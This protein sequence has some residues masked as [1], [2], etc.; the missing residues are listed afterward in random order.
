MT[1]RS[2]TEAIVTRLS[3][4]GARNPLNASDLQTTPPGPYTMVYSDAGQGRPLR[5]AS[6]TDRITVRWQ[7]MSV[8][9]SRQGVQDMVQDVRNAITDFS[10]GGTR[11][12]GRLSEEFS[13]PLMD[14]KTAP[15]DSRYSLTLNYVMTTHRGEV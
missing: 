5:I 2:L 15:L 14:I 3:D 1:L 10:P 8:S 11:E 12:S 9:N 7:I 13:G 6:E 4:Y